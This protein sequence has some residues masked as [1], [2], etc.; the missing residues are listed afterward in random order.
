VVARDYGADAI[1][2]FLVQRHGSMG[3]MGGKVAPSD[4][5]ERTHARIADVAQS[6]QH[7][8]WGD[9]IDHRAALARVV[10]AVRE[11]FEEAGMLIAPADAG[12]DLASLRAR[13]LG[14]EDFALLLEQE[15]LSLQLSLL[16]PLSRWVTP[17][18]EPVRFDTSFYVARAPEGQRAE[19]DEKESVAGRW[20]TPAAALQ[21]STAGEIRLA[22]PTA[23]TLEGLAQAGSVDAALE[24]ARSRPPPTILPIIRT[25]GDEV[26]I[27]YPG[28]P[29]HP[30]KTPALEGPTRRVLRRA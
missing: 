14:G 12:T 22:P 20:F 9:G 29:E 15:D 21:A 13:L 19:H 25:L 16:A 18:S 10:A 5:L 6:I 7:Q 26:V 23:R 1:E 28:D 3:F 30:V 4:E 8:R 11:T 24:L 27:L 2:I 17:E